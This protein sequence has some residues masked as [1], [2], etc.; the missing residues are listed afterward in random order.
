[1]EARDWTLL[2]LA[3]AGE[4][5]PVQLQKSLF[6]LGRN[7]NEHQLATGNFYNF[8]AYDYGPFSSGIYADAEMLEQGK[9]I[10]IKRPPEVRYK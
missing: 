10:I 3:K 2:V 8:E 5:Q 6:L 1:M 4:L 7:L 9:L